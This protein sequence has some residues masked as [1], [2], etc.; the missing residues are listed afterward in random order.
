MI[1]FSESTTAPKSADSLKMPRRLAVAFCSLLLATIIACTTAKT[2]EAALLPGIRQAWPG[3]RKNMLYGAGAMLNDT[4]IE[5]EEAQELEARIDNLD[6][7]ISLRIS[8]GITASY[9]TQLYRL[10]MI[11]IER[12]RVSGEIGPGVAAS[13]IERLRQFDLAVQRLKELAP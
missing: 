1:W 11:G 5:L 10:G 12:R 9:S 13:L 7:A 3:V 6:L 4:S 2:H 8:E